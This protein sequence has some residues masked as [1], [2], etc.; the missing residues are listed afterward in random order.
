[1][2]YLGRAN[3]LIFAVLGCRRLAL[4]GTARFGCEGVGP[5]RPREAVMSQG[6]NSGGKG[7]E[8]VA[9]PISESKPFGPKEWN[10]A[11]QKLVSLSAQVQ[12]SMP[13]EG[14]PAATKS[15]K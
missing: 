1:M 6:R 3:C 2:G 7:K 15:E 10:V 13:R 11:A 12:K 14:T 8:Q 9:R 5:P 4:V